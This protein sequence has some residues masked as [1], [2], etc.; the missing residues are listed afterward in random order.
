M[1]REAQELERLSE[2]T[3]KARKIQ[4]LEENVQRAILVA[5]ILNEDQDTLILKIKLSTPGSANLGSLYKPSYPS[6]PT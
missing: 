1:E 5:K 3:M 2:E 4:G 6:P